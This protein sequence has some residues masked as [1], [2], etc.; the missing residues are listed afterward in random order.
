MG[1]Y[2]QSLIIFVSDHGE[3]FFEHGS[4]EHGR[5]LYTEVL[6]V[7]LIVKFPSDMKMKHRKVSHPAQHLDI[8]P[9]VL[10]SIGLKIPKDL[11]GRSLLHLLRAPGES[12]QSRKIFS[13]RVGGRK[14]RSI[15]DGEWKLIQQWGN[16]REIQLYNHDLDPGEK[17]NLFDENR[18][19]RGYLLSLLKARERAP[20]QKFQ[21]PKVKMDE[22]LR[23]QLKALGYLQ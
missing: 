21:P 16:E 4:W 3:E 12:S 14:Y 1:L 6:K 20:R 13:Y 9:T 7:P 5:T 18:V 8:V 2:K 15:M 10:D 17:V 22:N 11:E 23:K 19:R